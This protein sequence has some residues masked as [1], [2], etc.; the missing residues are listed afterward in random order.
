MKVKRR[1]LGERRR[2]GERK[3]EVNI[4]KKQITGLQGRERV[5]YVCPISSL[6]YSKHV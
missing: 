4:I 2:G 5:V 1:L 3:M 6:M